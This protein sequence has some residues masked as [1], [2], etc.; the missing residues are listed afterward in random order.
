M[1][2]L[3]ALR[4]EET[5]TEERIKEINYNNFKKANK[6]FHQLV[7]NERYYDSKEE[8]I[9]RRNCYI[10]VLESVLFPLLKEEET[11]KQAKQ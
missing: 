1:D 10:G 3:K 9:Y 6:E 5:L 4:G 8:M 11:L 2:L 7:P